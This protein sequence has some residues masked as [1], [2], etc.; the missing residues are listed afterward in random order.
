MVAPSPDYSKSA[1][2]HPR[3][4]LQRDPDSNN[5]LLSSVWPI[6]R[7]KSQSAG[8]DG[9]C[10]AENHTNYLSIEATFMPAKTRAKRI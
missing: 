2:G 4:L 5:G 6:T 3:C 8:R 9:I 7:E 10:S 1:V